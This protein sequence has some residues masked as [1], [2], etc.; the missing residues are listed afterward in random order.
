MIKQL[1]IG[2]YNKNKIY[3]TSLALQNFMHIP[4][5]NSKAASLYLH[6]EI[7]VEIY[8]HMILKKQTF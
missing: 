8:Q 2:T 4:V 6:C 7:E 1:K 5:K 3:V